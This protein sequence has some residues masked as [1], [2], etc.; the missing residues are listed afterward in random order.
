MDARLHRIQAACGELCDS[1]RATFGESIRG[2]KYGH[3]KAAVDCS[4]LLADNTGIDAIL[5]QE[6]PPREIPPQW[7]DEFTMHG[8]YPNIS[9]YVPPVKYEKLAGHTMHG[10]SIDQS[11]VTKGWGLADIDRLIGKARNDLHRTRS[12]RNRTKLLMPWQYHMLNYE[13]LH[14]LHTEAANASGRQVLIIG[15]GSPWV[16]A[17]TLAAGAAHVYTLE[18]ARLVTDH[19]QI[20]TLLPS[21]FLHG[22]RS[23]SLPKFD[24][25]VTCSS[26]E[27]SGLGRYNDGL[28]PWGD[29]LAV[30]RSWCVSAPHARMVIAVPTGSHAYWPE[31]NDEQTARENMNDMVLFNAGRTY[32]PVRWPFLMTNWIFEMRAN[33]G[34]NPS[35]GQSLYVWQKVRAGRSSVKGWRML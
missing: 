8:R 33:F 1:R 5:E 4:W 17:V 32:G 21:E 29:V 26:V 25:I 31:P 27:H 2:V 6:V 19:P 24:L 7:L 10:D 15:S 13:L 16:E 30:A 34:F 14:V 11:T 22:A 18:Y 3:S 9:Q 12:R 35:W 28:N 20:T 23:S